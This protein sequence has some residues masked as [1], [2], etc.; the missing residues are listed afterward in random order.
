[1]FW[2]TDIE[3]LETHLSTNLINVNNP[4]KTYMNCKDVGHFSIIIKYNIIDDNIKQGKNRPLSFST[5]S[6]LFMLKNAPIEKYN[7]AD[8]LKPGYDG[9]YPITPNNIRNKIKKYLNFLMH[10]NNKGDAIHIPI[11]SLR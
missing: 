8:D 5:I 9:R 7:K 3:Y 2:D 4:T 6:K 10:Q 1:M 11:K